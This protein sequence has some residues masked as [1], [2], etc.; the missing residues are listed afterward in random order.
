MA[1]VPLLG[2]PSVLSTTSWTAPLTIR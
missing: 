2:L 1:R